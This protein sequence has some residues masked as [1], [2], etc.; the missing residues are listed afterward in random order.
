MKTLQDQVNDLIK[1]I[2]ARSDR[3]NQLYGRDRERWVA[4]GRRATLGRATQCLR[5]MPKSDLYSALQEYLNCLDKW[6]VD[7]E[8]RYEE[9]IEN[10]KAEGEAKEVRWIAQQVCRLVETN[11]PSQV[12]PFTLSPDGLAASE[13]SLL[14]EQAQLL[15]V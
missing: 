4:R 9:Q 8:E 15:R 7:A 10:W 6:S 2:R 11:I 12:V 3:L 1:R 13:E 14:D 5:S